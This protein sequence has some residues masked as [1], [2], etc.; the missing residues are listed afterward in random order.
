MKAALVTA[1]QKPEYQQ[2]LE[3]GGELIQ[4]G[5]RKISHY[6]FA[7]K[8]DTENLALNVSKKALRKSREIHNSVLNIQE[9]FLLR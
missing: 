4:L 8:I 1:E 7:S 6:L 2:Y 5:K 9:A 3:P